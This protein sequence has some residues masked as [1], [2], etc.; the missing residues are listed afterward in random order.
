MR[1]EKSSAVAAGSNDFHSLEPG[2]KIA[3]TTVFL[4][5]TLNENLDALALVSGRPK[6]EI[7]REALSEFIGKQKGFDPKRKP[8]I[9]VSY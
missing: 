9:V 4:T 3:R 5:E 1:K 2:A 6:G 8:K 7:V